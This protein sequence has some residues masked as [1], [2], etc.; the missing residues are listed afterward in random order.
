[1]V[2]GFTLQ[3]ANLY[4]YVLCKLGGDSDL[5]RVTATVLS[6]AVFRT[7]SSGGLPLTSS[8]H[9]QTEYEL[10]RGTETDTLHV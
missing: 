1:M 7:V 4:G 5:S 8:Q 2:A 6:R 3:A 9:A 10:A